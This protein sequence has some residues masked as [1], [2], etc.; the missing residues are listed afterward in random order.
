MTQI[1]RAW[2]AAGAWLARNPVTLTLILLG[3]AL[4]FTSCMAYNVV[5]SNE[6]WAAVSAVCTGLAGIGATVT[7]VHLIYVRA[8]QGS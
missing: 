4:L 5:A 3:F 2:H 1:R 7:A 6:A 8:G